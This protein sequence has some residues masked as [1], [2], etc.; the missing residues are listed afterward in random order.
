[1]KNA[2]TQRRFHSIL[3]VIAVAIIAVGTAIPI[4]PASTGLLAAGPSPAPGFPDVC[5]PVFPAGEECCL[6]RVQKRVEGERSIEYRTPYKCDTG[7]TN[8]GET[9]IKAE[10]NSGGLPC[11]EFS[12]LIPDGS[13]LSARGATLRRKDGFSNFN[14]KFVILKAGSGDTIFEGTLELSERLGSH[15]TPFGSEVCDPISHNEGWLVGRGVNGLE[16]FTIRAIIVL[17][18]Q[19]PPTD[20]STPILGSFDGSLIKCP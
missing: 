15:H 4:S 6:F 17:R 5:I 12:V 3:R 16:S 18:G 13:I 10:L 11:D 2:A 8:Q 7:E 9:S 14:G 19:L 20:G 1:M